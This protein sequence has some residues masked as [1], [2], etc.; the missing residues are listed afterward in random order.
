MVRR[1]WRVVLFVAVVALLS[2]WPAAAQVP[3]VIKFGG[4]LAGGGAARTVNATFSVYADLNGDAPLWQETQPVA[5]DAAGRY[6]VLLGAT[7]SDGLPTALFASGEAR[8]IGVR[9]EGYDEPSRVA[10]VSVPYALEAGNATTIGGK[11][12]SAFVMAGQSTGVGTDG[13]IYVD[14]RVLQNG[15]TAPAG[16]PSP[17]GGSG[18]AGTANYL[19][20]FTDATNLANSSIYQ[21]PAGR[22]GIN[23][24]DPAAPFNLAAAETPGAFFDVYSGGGVLGALPVVY[25]AS[26]GTAA[27]PAA[28]QTD[29][30][31]G[32]L[33]VRAF[34]GSAFTG[35][36][37]QV[38]FKAAENWTPT[39]NGTYLAM[40]TEPIGSS[41]P[42]VERIRITPD[43]K[44]GIGTTA[45]AYALSVAGT[46]ESRAGG[47]ALSALA[48]APS[49]RK[50][51]RGR[52][53]CTGCSPLLV[54]ATASSEVPATTLTDSLVG[55]AAGLGGVLRTTTVRRAGR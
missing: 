52:V 18:A 12:L 30:I 44:V 1:G 9:A 49:C 15:L 54:L 19:A 35:G 7:Q 14:A 4:V 22:I 17:Q 10:L 38:M 3:N 34:N 8:W 11:P 13:L 33:A 36:R 5:V 53:V 47:V 25:R 51:P 29:D 42:A 55:V 16:P 2:S 23:T 46:I 50:M 27:T 48:K 28:V 6:A 32:G 21:T 43:G 41:A 37:G 39:A 26:R 31:L 24:T 20:L 45:P 40:A